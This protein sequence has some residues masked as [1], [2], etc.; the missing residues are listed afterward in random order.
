ME[1]IVDFRSVVQLNTFL[2]LL[3]LS[4]KGH[5]AFLIFLSHIF[6]NEVSFFDNPSKTFT[7][8]EFCLERQQKWGQLDT[9]LAI[10]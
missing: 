9:E 3:V 6:V 5:A 4:S 10:L 2:L 7:M 8:L 1:I